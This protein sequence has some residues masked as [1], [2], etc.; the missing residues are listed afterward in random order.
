MKRSSG[1]QVPTPF[2]TQ[3]RVMFSVELL[4]S[5]A[6]HGQHLAAHPGSRRRAE[7]QRGMR[8]LIAYQNF[9]AKADQVKNDLIAFLIEQKRAGSPVAGYGAAAKG[10]T[11]LN[12]AGVKPD[13]L[14]Y[15]CDAAPSKQGKYLPGNHIPVMPPDTLQKLRPDFVLILPWNIADEVTGQHRYIRD[16]GGRFVVAVPSIRMLS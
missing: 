13:L 2:R 14:P 5:A 12:Y 4:D 11:L 8:R 9:Q 16:W 15:V 10:N 7:E 3:A 6:A 1:W